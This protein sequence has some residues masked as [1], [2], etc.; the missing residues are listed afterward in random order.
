MASNR[1]RLLWENSIPLRDAWRHFASNADQGLL[2]EMPRALEAMTKFA[3]DH[4]GN[5]LKAIADAIAIGVRTSQEHRAVQDRLR[6]DL[7]TDLFNEQLIATGFRERPS[8]SGAPVLIEAGHFAECVAD[9][10]QSKIEANGRLWNRVRI[11]PPEKPIVRKVP[12][13]R[14]AIEVAICALVA[15]NADFAKA[16]GKIRC[17]A[18]RAEIGQNYVPGN[19]L[20]DQNIERHFV[21]ICGIK[22]ISKNQK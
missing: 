5:G 15:K 10:E 3:S 9:W 16:P 2:D 12:N 7:L 20:S 11:S 4:A 1:A 18:V 14:D 22:R 6:E 21:R 17:D 8:L 13:S 19:G